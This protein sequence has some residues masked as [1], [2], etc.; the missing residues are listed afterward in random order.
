MSIDT[1]TGTWKA[2]ETHLKARIELLRGQLETM[3]TDDA[4]LR[5]RAHI[6]ACRDLLALPETLA[7]LPLTY[8]DNNL[9]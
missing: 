6:A 8:D 7:T 5:T 3:Q 9:G 2:I 1:E 4:T